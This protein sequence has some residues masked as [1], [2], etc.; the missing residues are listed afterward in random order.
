[1]TTCNNTYPINS[2]YSLLHKQILNE[3]LQISQNDPDINNILNSLVQLNV[4][5]YNIVNNQYIMSRIMSVLE[6]NYKEKSIEIIKEI[7]KIG[8]QLY[9]NEQLKITYLN[10]MF[11]NLG[12]KPQPVD[13]HARSQL[14]YNV[15]K[16]IKIPVE[17]IEYTNHSCGI[18]LNDNSLFNFIMSNVKV[19]DIGCGPGNFLGELEK[20]KEDLFGLDVVS[21]VNS[22]YINKINVL[23]YENDLRIPDN[24]NVKYSF[25][26]FFMV[27]HHISVEKIDKILFQLYDK[28]N[29]DGFLFIK[30]H[31][32]ECIDDLSFFKFME[33]YFYLVEEY[34]PSIPIQ[35]NYFMKNTMINIITMYG[36][37]KIVSFECNKNQ[38]F[39]PCYFLFKKNPDYTKNSNIN[40]RLSQLQEII[41]INNLN[42]NKTNCNINCDIRSANMK[43]MKYK[44]KYLNLKSSL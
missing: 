13:H 4:L 20:R 38:P 43:Y 41:N 36:F 16:T 27:L 7:Y 1:M 32:V 6:Y 10:I 14:E 35:N 31:N 44:K 15:L 22:N 40:E 18:L 11:K 21:Y 19:L 2:K 26:S 37:N 3:S 39:K 33:I 34:I 23:T 30:D 8:L 24:N 29:N 5:L 25:I 42:L 12:F 17:P 9:I 28:L